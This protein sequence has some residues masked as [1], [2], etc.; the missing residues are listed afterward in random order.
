MRGATQHARG[1]SELGHGVD[2]F[3]NVGLNDGDV[4]IARKSCLSY[5]SEL[6]ALRS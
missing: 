5:V 6:A 1:T 2:M 4:V 3:L